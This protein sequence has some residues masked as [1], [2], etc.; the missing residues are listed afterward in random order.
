MIHHLASTRSFGRSVDVG[1]HVVL[2]ISRE[3]ESTIKMLGN[4]IPLGF[5]GRFSGKLTRKVQVGGEWDL[6]LSKMT[7]L[8]S[9]PNCCLLQKIPS[10]CSSETIPSSHSWLVVPGCFSQEEVNPLTRD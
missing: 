8:L 7:L 10:C 3:R 6:E 9:T 5:G 4:T 2:N 1:S